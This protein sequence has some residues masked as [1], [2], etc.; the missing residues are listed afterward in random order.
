MNGPSLMGLFADM[1]TGN[2]SD[3]ECS[4]RPAA[5]ADGGILVS[6]PG[7]ARETRVGQAADDGN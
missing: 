1:A 3:T 6:P 2:S 5:T 7:D 4:G